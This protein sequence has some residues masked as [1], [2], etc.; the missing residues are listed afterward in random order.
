MSPLVEG[1]GPHLDEGLQE[2]TLGVG[3]L[4]FPLAKTKVN[5]VSGVPV[6]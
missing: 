3:L 4:V 6:C 5:F 2:R 1:D